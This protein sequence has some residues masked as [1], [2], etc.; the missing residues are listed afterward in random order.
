MAGKRGRSGP[1]KGN[2]N[3]ARSVVPALKRLQQGKTLPAH[4]ER[5]A[6]LAEMEKS[7]LVSDK[8]GWEMMSGAERLMVGNWA[9]ARKAE[10]LIWNE[11]IERGA[12]TEKNGT[13]DLQPGLQRLAGFLLSQHRA[14]TALGL[15]RRAKDIT[16]LQTYLAE[17]E[18]E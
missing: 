18:A 8:G 13:W 17:K 12:V 16:D 11:L 10:L 7:E 1:P 3:A 4:L 6:A 15:E 9:S 14:L 5:V 2:L